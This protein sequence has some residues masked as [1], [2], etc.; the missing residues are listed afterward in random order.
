MRGPG[1]SPTV[2]IICAGVSLLT[3]CLAARVAWTGEFR[4]KGGDVVPLG[5]AAMTLV[6]GPLVLMALISLWVAVS[7][8]GD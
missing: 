5:P 2:Q 1:A 6:V 4:A 7:G 3:G 8:R